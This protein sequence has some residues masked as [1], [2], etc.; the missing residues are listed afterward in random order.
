M[1]T[2]VT[3]HPAEIATPILMT[4]HIVN[5]PLSQTY[6]L[7]SSI[8]RGAGLFVVRLSSYALKLFLSRDNSIGF[9]VTA[10]NSSSSFSFS[11]QVHFYPS[12]THENC[13]LRNTRSIRMDHEALGY[14]RL[15][16]ATN[17]SS[18]KSLNGSVDHL[19]RRWK[20]I[21]KQVPFYI[22]GQ[23]CRQVVITRRDRY[24]WN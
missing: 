3:S 20:P 23:I 13:K 14:F 16:H 8:K 11:F 17:T 10:Y 21:M 24:R 6:L 22:I 18:S 4:R 7:L 2:I 15:L 9:F 1:S 19:Q 12:V 5:R